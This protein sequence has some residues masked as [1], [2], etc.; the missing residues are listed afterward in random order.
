[1]I[2][3][4]SIG[5]LLFF[6]LL[7]CSFLIF[8]Y[9]SISS[10]GLLSLL[11]KLLALRSIKAFKLAIFSIIYLAKTN[12]TAHSEG[13]GSLPR[14]TAENKY[15]GCFRRQSETKRSFFGFS[16]S[17]DCCPCS[18]LDPERSTY[19]ENIFRLLSNLLQYVLM[20]LLQKLAHLL[21]PA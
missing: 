19:G 15:Q 21:E 9:F 12:R 18:S 8:F 10:L 1:M 16:R 4:D 5:I 11:T 6:P 2:L 3:V 17:F 7:L 14:I 20:L 13:P